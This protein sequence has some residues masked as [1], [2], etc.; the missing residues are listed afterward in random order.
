MDPQGAK[1]VTVLPQGAPRLLQGV[2]RNLSI[3]LCHEHLSHLASV[4]TSR[5]ACS[6]CVREPLSEPCRSNQCI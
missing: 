5:S 2:Q 3:S 1:L 6:L 4:S